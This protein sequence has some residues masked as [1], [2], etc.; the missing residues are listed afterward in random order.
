MV[1]LGKNL[2]RDAAFRAVG[3]AAEALSRQVLLRV[4]GPAPDPLGPL[5]EHVR[6]LAELSDSLKKKRSPTTAVPKPPQVPASGPDRREIA[7]GCLPCARGHLSA[8]AASLKEALRFARDEGIESHEVQSRLQ[9]AE[10][11]VTA[12]ERH[13]WT[14]E[15][16]LAS[17]PEQQEVIRRLLPMLR[18]LRQDIM[19]IR[20]VEDLE[21]A[22]AKAAELSV[23]LRMEVLRLQGVDTGKMVTLAQ[24]VANGEMTV[25]EARAELQ[26]GLGEGE[27]ST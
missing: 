23:R 19:T 13:D 26:G 22:S 1:A 4:L 11:E 9:T 27:G 20:R 17:P 7:V 5:R 6:N 14:P 25:E 18:E 2:L 12:L 16:I 15:R 24:K 3:P 21:N 10:E 8:V